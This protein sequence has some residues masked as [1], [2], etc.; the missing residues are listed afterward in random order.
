VRLGNLLTNSVADRDWRRHVDVVFTVVVWT[1]NK[2]YV[3]FTKEAK[4][5]E[6]CNKK[7]YST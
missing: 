7:G 5:K 1:I 6:F 3:V 2:P 4:V